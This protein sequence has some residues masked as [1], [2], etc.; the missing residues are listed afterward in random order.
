MLTSLEAAKLKLSAYYRDTDRI[1]GHIYVIGTILSPQD[2]LKFFSTSDW[3]PDPESGVDY[4]AAYRQSLESFL[5]KYSKSFAED[6]QRL[7]APMASSTPDEFDLACALDES[8]QSQ[9]T[10]LV[11]SDELTRYLGSSK[12]PLSSI[13]ESNY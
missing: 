7:D 12:Y 1:D 3:D 5:E 9:I 2:K 4:R 13:R 11:Q 8:Q 10:Q 6:Y